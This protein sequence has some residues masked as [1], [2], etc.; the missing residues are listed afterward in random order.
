MISSFYLVGVLRLSSEN[1]LT[2]KHFLANQLTKRDNLQIP[3]WQ[4]FAVL[5]TGAVIVV[6]NQTAMSTALP[7]MIESLGIDPSPVSYTHL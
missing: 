1:K 5:F 6:L 4:I 2:F 3:R 7:N